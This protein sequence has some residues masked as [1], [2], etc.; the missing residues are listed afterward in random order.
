MFKPF[1]EDPIL[2]IL[3]FFYNYT[4]SL[5]FAIILLTL[6]IK[7]ILFPFMIPTYKNMKKQ[8][9]IKPL[10]DKIKEK[11]KDD[12]KKQAEEQMKVF[13]E[14]GINPT[15][16]CLT[17]IVTIVV[18][19]G[20]YQVINRFTHTSNLSDLNNDIYFAFMKFSEG[21]VIKSTFGYL[22]LVKPDTSLILPIISALFTFITSAMMLPELTKEEKVAKEASTDQMEVMAYSMQ[23]Q[24]TV[25]AP[26]MT[27]IVGITIPAGL[28]LYITV[29]SIF[30]F[31]QQYYF[32]GNLGGLRP[33]IRLIKE[34][35]IKK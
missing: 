21:E 35:V 33:Y 15:S 12:R 20:L 16:G 24:M 19:I 5:G 28:T 4:F 34:K 7:T 25:L 9:E 31:F 30:S 10:L 23:K 26:A 13:K 14:H 22:D 32:L 17:Q 1:V 27:F 8:K 18:L 3:T 6:F 2:N 11:Y 29:S